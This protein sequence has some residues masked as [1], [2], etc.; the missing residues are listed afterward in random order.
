MFVFTSVK[1]E[2]PSCEYFGSSEREQIES[3]INIALDILTVEALSESEIERTSSITGTTSRTR[4]RVIRKWKEQSGRTIRPEIV[5]ETWFS[6][7]LQ[8]EVGES[9]L[10]YTTFNAGSYL[11]Y[12]NICMGT[13]NIKDVSKLEWELNSEIH[14]NYKN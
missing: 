12:T 10:M 3:Q 11:F 2:S 9:Y 5:V 13:K 6:D 4:F 1:A 7:K 14:N 8:Y